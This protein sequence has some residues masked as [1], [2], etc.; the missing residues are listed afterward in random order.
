[1]KNPDFSVS[2]NLDSL[3]VG[4]QLSPRVVEA[5]GSSLQTSLAIIKDRWQTEAQT[6]LNSSR[7]LY[8]MGLS[9]DSVVYPYDSPFSGAVI[10]QGQLPNMLETGFS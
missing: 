7:S 1:M 4:D 8:L 3:G 2:V 9:F 6:K 10:L 5:I